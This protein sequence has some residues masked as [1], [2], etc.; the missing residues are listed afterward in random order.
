M[1]MMTTALNAQPLSDGSGEALQAEET[2]DM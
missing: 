1:E 2:K